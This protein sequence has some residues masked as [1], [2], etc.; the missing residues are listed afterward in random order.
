MIGV[1][2][3]TNLV[4]GKVYIGSSRNIKKR[5]TD[6]FKPS[7]ISSRIKYPLYQDISKYGRKNFRIEILEECR[8]ENLEELETKYIQQYFG[9]NCYNVSETSHNMKS[10]EGKKIHGEFFSEWNKQQWGKESYRNER[11]KSSREIQLKRLEN[12]EYLEEK[13]KQLKKYTDTLKK[14]VGQFDKQG[15]LINTFEGTREAERKTGINSSQI[16]AVALGKP[17]RKT[18]GGYV[19]KY[20]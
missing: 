20:L 13:S 8:I 16:S 19:W 3:I 14:K 15:N 9:E 7:K 2:K 17:K 11:S 1:Y 10:E 4:N 18:A 5:I 6:H 12:P